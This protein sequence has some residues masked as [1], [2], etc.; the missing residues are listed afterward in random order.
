MVTHGI[1]HQLIREKF[2]KEFFTECYGLTM[3]QLIREKFNFASG[4]SISF[5]IGCS[6]V[7]FLFTKSGSVSRITYVP[8]NFEMLTR[9]HEYLWMETEECTHVCL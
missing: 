5:L 4:K 6:E 1:L 9:P 3:H 2:E 7:Y 8:E